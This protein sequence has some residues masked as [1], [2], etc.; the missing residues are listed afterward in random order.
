M[1]KKRIIF[2]LLFSEGYFNLSRNFRLQRIG[3]INWLLNNYDFSNVSRSIDEL[4]VLDVTKGKRDST[5][6]LDAVRK[7]SEDVFIPISLGGGIRNFDDAKIFFD[8]GADKIIINTS[9]FDNSKLIDDISSV[10]GSQSIVAYLD[11]KKEQENFFLYKNNGSEKAKVKTSEFIN[12][13]AD[14]NIGELVINSIDKDGTGMDFLY[15]T[16]DLLPFDITIP[17]LLSGGAGNF[18]H[19]YSALSDNRIDA[20][21]T[22]NLLNFVG[23]GLVTARK[24]IIGNGI[25]LAVWN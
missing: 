17:V 3:D 21:V 5:L 1:L 15:Q 14:K 24:E 20:V 4:I 2:S 22:A 18:K 25:N 9:L 16:I 11:I 7:I 12:D 19:L 10:Y 6:F 8:S 13:I 23:D